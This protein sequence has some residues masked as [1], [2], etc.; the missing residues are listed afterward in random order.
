MLCLL[1]SVEELTSILLKC[2]KGRNLAHA[3]RM[4]AYLGD[5]GLEAHASLGNCLVFVLVQVESICHA[6]QVFDR[7]LLRDKRSWNSL[8]IG[9]AKYG[10]PQ[11][12][13][14]LYQ[15]MLENDSLDPSA[16]SFI[17]LL[18]VCSAL[19]D[20][21]RGQELHIEIAR[22]NLLEQNVFIGSSLVN[23]YAKCSALEMAHD[24]FD[25]LAVRD[26]YLWNALIGVYVEHGQ[27]ED[28][29]MFFEQMQLDST[30]PDAATF[31]CCLK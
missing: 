5:L 10:D 21:E 9:H 7:L 25:K 30:S 2:S 15:L 22:R 29:L 14:A 19:N 26:V 3:L 6:E 8:I 4:Q 31:V 27:C 23:M 18:K 1:P 20:L 13:L 17:A 28:A 24:V 16:Y 12:A 11:H